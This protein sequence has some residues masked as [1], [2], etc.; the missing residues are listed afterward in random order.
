MTSYSENISNI[1]DAVIARLND[2][3]D[4]IN[5]PVIEDRKSVV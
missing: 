1:V 2:N 5:N 4:A 3:L